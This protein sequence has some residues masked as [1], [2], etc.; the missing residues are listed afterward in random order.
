MLYLLNLSISPVRNNQN[1]VIDGVVLVQDISE[2][3]K[4]EQMRKDFIS[5]VSHEFRT[6]LTVIKGNLESIVDGM[7]KPE[8]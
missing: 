3:E 7:T 1:Q 5:N 8:L 6:P 4:L 2:K